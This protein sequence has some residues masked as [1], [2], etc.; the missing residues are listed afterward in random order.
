[1]SKPPETQKFLTRA[2]IF[3]PL[4]FSHLTSMA[5]WHGSKTPCRSK[6]PALPVPPST[7]S[8]QFNP[9]TILPFPP[10]PWIQTHPKNFSIASLPLQ[11]WTTVKFH[12]HSRF[13]LPFPSLSFLCIFI[14]FTQIFAHL[15]VSFLVKLRNFTPS[16]SLCPSWFYSNWDSYLQFSADS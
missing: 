16:V 8:L 12:Y 15:S 11:N 2:S 5:W 1:M 7:S 14:C 6:L 13:P 9:I 4:I 10:N 3:G